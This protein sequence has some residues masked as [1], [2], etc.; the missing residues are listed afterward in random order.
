MLVLM[1]L[2]ASCSFQRETS[3]Q[4]NIAVGE[5]LNAPQG[6]MLIPTKP[7][8]LFVSPDSISLVLMPLRASCS[9]QRAPRLADSAATLTGLNAPQGFM[10]IPT[11]DLSWTSVFA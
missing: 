6:F 5:G 11:V 3:V 4:V 2:R 8:G 10:L 1:P 9:F 7:L